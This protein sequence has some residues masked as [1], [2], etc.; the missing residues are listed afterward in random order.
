[1]STAS[2]VLVRA[3]LRS[4]TSKQAVTGD[5]RRFLRVAPA[6]GIV[7]LAV[8]V[9]L[10]VRSS[11]GL[12]N[13]LVNFGYLAAVGGGL[14]YGAGA[15]AASG[16]LMALPYGPI[17]AA[18]GMNVDRPEAW[19]VRLTVLVG[20]GTLTGLMADRN[21][22]VAARWQETA[23]RVIEQQRSGMLA[24]ARGAE[25]KD[26]P[27]GDH[28]RR[29]QVTAE[30][31]AKATGLDASIAEDIGWAAMLHDV[32]KLHMPDSILSKPGPLTPDEWAI[33]RNH[34]IWGEAILDGAGGF[35]LARVVARSHHENFDGSGY[36]DGLAGERIPI[37]ARIV[38]IAD[39]FD[40]MTND[41]LYSTPR[42]YDDAIE[43]LYRYKGRQFDPELVDLMSRLL[44][45]G[46]LLARVL[47]APSLRREPSEPWIGVDA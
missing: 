6:L 21:R 3:R 14:A 42:S 38:R 35:E 36:P 41:R 24:L 2:H 17:G 4:R 20:V 25:A 27:T 5:V 34:P 11:G 16:L 18:T 29:V 39:A 28:I 13:V 23:V 7:G 32:G 22:A 40:A 47:W 9:F 30:E 31:L 45:T 8:L 15:G 46:N 1:M 26:K 37:E 43:E 44:R 12:P 33:V 19:L 10:L